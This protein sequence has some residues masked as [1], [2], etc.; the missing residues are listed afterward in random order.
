M[1]A[2]T[3]FWSLLGLNVLA[4]GAV[5]W[6]LQ[7]ESSVASV[8]QPPTA[9]RIVLAPDKPIDTAASAAASAASAP[10]AAVEPPPPAAANAS[11]ASAAPVLAAPEPKLYC[12]TLDNL[13]R[14]QLTGARNAVHHVW[15]DLA[16][17]ESFLEDKAKY[18]VFI[19]P[20]GGVDGAVATVETIRQQGVEEAFIVRDTGPQQYAVS[21]GLFG[22]KASA[23]FFADQ[24]K[25]KGVEG[26]VV[27][28]HPRSKYARLSLSNV[29]EKIW[30]SVREV[31][32]RQGLMVPPGQECG[33]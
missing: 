19:P 31:L 20:K 22:K 1:T 13:T 23:Q 7:H 12:L 33:G 3:L 8:A 4:A 21:L 29:S 15:P 28:P 25:A 10:V 26:V 24:L 30:K 2:K 17:E 32:T 6:S 18:W 9:S 14:E 27:E 11:S 16:L 5:Y